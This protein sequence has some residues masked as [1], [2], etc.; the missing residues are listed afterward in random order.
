MKKNKIFIACDSTNLTKIK[1][2]IS[3]T[4]TTKLKIGYKFGLEFLNSKEGRSFIAKIKNKI[5]FADL[6]LHDIPNTCAST[7]KAIKDLKVNYLTIHVSS[8][9]KA[10]K[11]SKKVSGK[12]KLIGVTTLTSFDNKSLKQIGYNKNLNKLVIHQAKLASK[13]NLDALVCSAHEVKDVKK[14]F[15][16]EII[17]PGIRFNSNMNDQKRVMTPKQAFK[18]GSDWLVIGRPITRGNINN[19][20]IKLINHLSK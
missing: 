14:F 5:V 19:N 8:G 18:N 6:K 11:V 12:T 15:K 7:V 1:E 17:T 20:L 13:A 9:L 2:I 16:K 3:K 4:Q 10:L